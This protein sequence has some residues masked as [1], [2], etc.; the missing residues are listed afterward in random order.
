MKKIA[1]I[2]QRYGKEVN[3]GSEYYTMLMAQKL[4]ALYEVEVLTSKALTYEKWENYYQ[5]DIQNIDDITVRRFGVKRKRNKYFQRLLKE[6][7][8]H[9]GWNT[10]KMTGLWNMVLGPYIPEMLSYIEEHKEEYDAFIFVTYMYYPAVF[11]MEKVADKSVFVPTAHDEYNIYFKIYERIFHLPR[12]IVY[13]TEEEKQFVQERFHNEEMDS[14]VIGV[15]IEVP[16]DVS[17]ERFRKKY[18]IDGEYIIYAGRVDNEKGCNEMFDYFLR[19]ISDNGNMQLVVIGKSYMD[20]PK[21]KRIHYIGYVSEQDKYDGIK[22]AKLLWLPSRFESL[23]IAVL[24]AMALRTP[25]IVNGRCNVLRG[26]CERS[27]GGAWYERYGEFV[28]SM[29]KVMGADYNTFCDNSEQYVRKFYRWDKVISQWRTLLE[30][31]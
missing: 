28:D 29:Q 12:K 22:G 16:L 18:D 25:V 27:G 8:V 1:F 9:L 5:E 15:G 4:K 19:Y 23:S 26:H 24:E 10:E 17:E 31:V 2:N 21:D 14:S 30:K 13:L 6:L 11:G 20:I 3:G 7:I